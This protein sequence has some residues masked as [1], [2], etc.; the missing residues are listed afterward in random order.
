MEERAPWTQQPR[1]T[2]VPLFLAVHGQLW[3]RRADQGRA[4]PGRGPA[5][6]GLLR[7][8]EAHHL[9]GL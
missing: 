1:M 4:V 7:A 9:H 6:P 2:V 3:G 5:S 8:P